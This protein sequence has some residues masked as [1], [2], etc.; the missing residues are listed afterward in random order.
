MEQWV[1]EAKQMW[2]KDCVNEGLN[3][4]GGDLGKWSAVGRQLVGSWSAVGRQLV[5]TLQPT[6]GDFFPTQRIAFSSAPV[7][8]R[9]SDISFR[10]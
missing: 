6:C 7:R 9:R 1:G 5:G 2:E 10:E 8:L 4:S 3:C